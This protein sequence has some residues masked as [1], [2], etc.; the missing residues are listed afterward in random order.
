LK[1]LTDFDDRIEGGIEFH[2]I[3]EEMRKEEWCSSLCERSMKSRLS[4]TFVTLRRKGFE[5]MKEIRWFLKI[6]D[7]ENEG[8]LVK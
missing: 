5:I 1:I 4:L 3:D 8:R 7:F 2:K 6:K